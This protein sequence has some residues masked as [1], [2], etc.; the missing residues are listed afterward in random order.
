MLNVTLAHTL[1]QRRCRIGR[2]LRRRQQLRLQKHQ[3]PLIQLIHQIQLQ[4]LTQLN[5][6]TLQR[7]LK[8]HLKLL[9]QPQKQLNLLTLLTQLNQPRRQTPLS[10][11]MHQTQLT[12]LQLLTQLKHRKRQ[13]RQQPEQS[14]RVQYRTN[15]HLGNFFIM[16]RKDTF[17][18]FFS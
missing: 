15:G 13:N 4:L 3:I 5:Q 1:F 17:C 2:L 11:P 6:L 14:R 9:T 8:H 7:P 12:Q 10:Q 18:R 16:E